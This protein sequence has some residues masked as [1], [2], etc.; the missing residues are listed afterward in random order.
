MRY[1]WWISLSWCIIV[2]GELAVAFRSA[3]F[4]FRK[5]LTET[6]LRPKTQPFGIIHETSFCRHNQIIQYDWG[7]NLAS[8]EA[9]DLEALQAL[10][11]QY[12][13]KEGLMTK[14][15]VEKVPAIAELFVSTR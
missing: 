2:L 10:F 4:L 9:N 15:D 5:G 6:T 7:L 8:S 12:C 13:D 1:P 3:P 14:T 11:A